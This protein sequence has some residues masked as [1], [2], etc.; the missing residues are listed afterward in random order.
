MET[1]SALLAICARNSSVPGE[2]PTQKPVTRSF[3]VYF[4]LRPDQRLSKQS[5][6]WWFETL[7]HSLWRHQK[8]LSAACDTWKTICNVEVVGASNDDRYGTELYCVPHAYRQPKL[9]TNSHL[10][11][12]W[13][14]V[15][16]LKLIYR[17]V[18]NIRRTK[19]QNLNASRLIW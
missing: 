13:S 11:D 9:T 17:E 10:S 2:F 8:N 14:K 4:D 5:L 18:S 3:D 16:T 12:D 7:S 19:S 1:F 15:I 6:G